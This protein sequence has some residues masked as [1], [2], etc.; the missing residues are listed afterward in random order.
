MRV[1]VCVCL[2]AGANVVL[3]GDMHLPFGQL[4]LLLYSGEVTL[5]TGSG[6]AASLIL[7]THKY[8]DRQTDPAAVSISS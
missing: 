8:D 1:R 5:L 2:D 3:V 7:D 6:R 4:P